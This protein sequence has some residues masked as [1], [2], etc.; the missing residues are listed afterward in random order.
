[1]SFRLQWPVATSTVIT[2]YMSERPQVYQ[3][4]RLP[5]HDGIDFGSQIGDEIY[6]AAD[7]I[8]LTS[9]FDQTGFGEMIRIVH[10]YEGETFETLYAHLNSRLVTQGTRVSAGD[11]IA[12]SGNSGFSEGPH[13]HFG[14]YLKGA[15][16]RGFSKFESISDGTVFA[17]PWD[18]IDPAPWLNPPLGN[19]PV[20][21]SRSDH[22]A[23]SI[24]D[25]SGSG[26]PIGAASVEV[27]VNVDGLKIRQDPS[28]N[29]A[30]L[31][32]LEKGTRLTIDTVD[33]VV[34]AITWRQIELPIEYKD[35]WIAMRLGDSH[36]LIPIRATEPT[37][38]DAPETS[39]VV[40]NSDE[41]NVWIEP[42]TVGAPLARLMRGARLE[43]DTDEIIDGIITWRKVIEPA[44]YRGRWVPIKQGSARL[45]VPSPVG[46]RI[47]ADPDASPR[48]G[49]VID[50]VPAAMRLP[51]PSVP[52]V[53]MVVTNSG[54]QRLAIRTHPSTQQGSVVDRVSD[55]TVLWVTEDENPTGNVTWRQIISPGELKDRWV[56]QNLLDI[57]YLLPAPPEL[58][59]PITG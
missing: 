15:T 13:L 59:E 6:A 38:P 34:G 27:E 7:G 32:A 30:P 24:Q 33:L 18:Q 25:A 4:F 28:T 10:E 17:F 45:A 51:R 9:K 40:I 54:T 29:N 48:A 55:G 1:M 42:K 49:G 44:R 35:K 23:V 36:Y 26:M 37:G 14:L 46:P 19:T 43:V 31:A 57:Q 52:S 16:R 11:V 22:P 50:N 56:A 47:E 8:V 41:V 12:L 3:R 21:P 39:F 58:L 2:Q 5:G 20:R 53:G